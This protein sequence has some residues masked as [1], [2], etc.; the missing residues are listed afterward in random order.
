MYLI[1]GLASHLSN[2]I[3]YNL[4]LF[5]N[6]ICNKYVIKSTTNQTNKKWTIVIMTCLV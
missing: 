6:K 2:G 1:F 3:K 5:L 4:H